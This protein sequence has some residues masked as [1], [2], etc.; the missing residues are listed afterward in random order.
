M[1][2]NIYPLGLQP[3]NQKRDLG[4]S[5]V[6]QILQVEGPGCTQAVT[7]QLRVLVVGLESTSDDSDWYF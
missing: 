6:L 5:H 1:D 7:G 4:Q 3:Q 2:Q